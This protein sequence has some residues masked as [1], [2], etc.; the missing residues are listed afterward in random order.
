MNRADAAAS[1]QLRHYLTGYWL[2]ILLTAIP[3]ALVA[4]GAFPRTATLTAIALAAALQILVHLRFFLHLSFSPHNTSF[5]IS[6]AFTAAIL[7]IMIG[8]SLWILF[9][10]NR[11]MLL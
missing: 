4:V 6:I 11:H 8:G 9:D 10:L 3:F 2:A 7:F 1:S 5:L